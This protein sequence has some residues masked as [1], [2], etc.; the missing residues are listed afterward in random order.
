M[1]LSVMLITYNHEPFIAQALESILAQRVNFDYEIVVGEDCSTDRTRDDSHGF[2]QSVS[3]PN[4]ASHTRSEP[5]H[6]A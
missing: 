6:D 4:C 5:G 3:W 2:S 1:K